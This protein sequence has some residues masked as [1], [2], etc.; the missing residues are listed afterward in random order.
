MLKF[1][2]NLGRGALMGSAEV[3]PGV[4]GGTLALIVGIY[5]MLINSIADLVLSVRQ[6]VGLAPGKA[7]TKTAVSTFKSLPWRL[8]IP[9]AIGMGAA[10]ILGA[11]LIE[12]LLD[13]QPIAMKALF[14]GLVIAGTYV[15]AHMVTKVGGWSSSFVLLG[16]ISAVFVFFL[17]GLPQG[18]VADPSLIVVFF[19]ASIAI[20]ALVLPG[21]SGSFLLLTVG[22][23]DPTIAAVNDRNFTYLIVFALGAILGLA[24][25]VSLL[26]WLLEN[27]ARVTLVIIT[28]LMLG[29]L[30]ALWPW[31]GP[32]RELL[33]P[34]DQIG[35]A[36]LLFIAGAAFVTI[37]LALE[38]KFG[39]TEEQKD[40]LET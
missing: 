8:L 40:L 33:A 19:W 6:L 16:L 13:E 29:S 5:Q 39:E 7:S 15:P 37:L 23:Y 25:F 1:I 10:V 24:I 2:T 14:F 27:R 4:S 20:C 12:P 34:T 18:N 30:R 22:M 36:L 32:E 11:K 17:T 9:V 26:K 28:G 35:I 3:V 31:Q 38:R 21:V